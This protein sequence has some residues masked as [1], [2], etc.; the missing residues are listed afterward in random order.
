MR[1]NL[2]PPSLELVNSC[3]RRPQAFSAHLPFAEM[4]SI[5]GREDALSSM[6]KATKWN[7]VR[8]CRSSQAT[9]PSTGRVM[10]ITH[11]TL[12]FRFSTFPDRVTKRTTYMIVFCM[13][14]QPSC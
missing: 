1:L 10:F 4:P 14:R 13:S 11:R 6:R 9:S 2:E 3:I 7:E 12:S 5:S 8:D